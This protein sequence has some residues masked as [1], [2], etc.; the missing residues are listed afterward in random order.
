MKRN[1]ENGVRIH[2][3]VLFASV[4]AIIVFVFIGKCDALQDLDW[5][6][7]VSWMKLIIWEMVINNLIK[8]PLQSWI[9]AYVEFCLRP[10]KYS[11]S[12]SLV[13]K[14]NCNFF[15][16]ICIAFNAI[17]QMQK[18]WANMSNK[19]FSVSHA[20]H[21]PNLRWTFMTRSLTKIA[22]KNVFFNEFSQLKWCAIEWPKPSCYLTV[23]MCEINVRQM[24]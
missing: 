16:F 15:F 5:E 1:G 2:F 21:Q 14:K 18:H 8:N 13:K 11:P 9:G 23:F 3:L 4:E 7:C 20:C 17:L 24:K 12:D 22:T 6:F 10:R 19:K